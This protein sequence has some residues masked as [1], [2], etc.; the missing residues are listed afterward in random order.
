MIESVPVTMPLGSSELVHLFAHNQRVA[1]IMA[2]L[3]AHHCVGAACQ[4]VNDLA[5]ALV[6]PLGADNGHICHG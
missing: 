6:T 3:K 4:P 2:A 5:F 1:R